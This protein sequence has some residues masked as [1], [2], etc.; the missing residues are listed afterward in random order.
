M[1]R[2]TETYTTQLVVQPRSARQIYPEDRQME[3]DD[4]MRVY[5]FLGDMTFERG[6]SSAPCMTDCLSV[7][8]RSKMTRLSPS[9]LQQAA[10]SMDEQRQEDRFDQGRWR[11]NRRIRVRGIH[12]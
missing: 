8:R 1:T 10:D 4:S 12:H 9:G 3:F 6:S 11:G 5:N 7:P 2:G